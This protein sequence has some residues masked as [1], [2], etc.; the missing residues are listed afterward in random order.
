MVALSAKEKFN[1]A[2]LDG[3]N[4]VEAR[5][6]GTTPPVVGRDAAGITAYKL[7]AVD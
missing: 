6:K 7:A 3:P 1:Y 4:R 5:D 2:V